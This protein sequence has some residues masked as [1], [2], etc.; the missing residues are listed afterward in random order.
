MIFRIRYYR[1]VF[2]SKIKKQKYMKRIACIDI[3]NAMKDL[4]ERRLVTKTL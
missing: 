4:G 2:I 1:V 3:Y